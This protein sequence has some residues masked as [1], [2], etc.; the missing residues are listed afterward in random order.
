MRAG[1]EEAEDG[2]NVVLFAFYCTFTKCL[3]FLHVVMR[4]LLWSIINCFNV[5]LEALRLIRQCVNL[6]NLSESVFNR[7]CVI[8][9]NDP[10][11]THRCRFPIEWFAREEK[12][13]YL[14]I[15]IR[16]LPF[17]YCADVHLATIELLC[18]W[19]ERSRF[20]LECWLLKLLESILSF[21]TDF[22]RWIPSTSHWT[23]TIIREESLPF[24]WP[25]AS[26]FGS[27]VISRVKFCDVKL[28]SADFIRIHVDTLRFPNEIS[29]RIYFAFEEFFLYPHSI[30]I[31]TQVDRSFKGTNE[32][33]KS[34]H[35]Q[36]NK[37]IKKSPTIYHL[38]FRMQRA[39]GEKCVI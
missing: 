2:I 6:H 37:Q 25:F 24:T 31:L 36:A 15:N 12:I 30:R 20:K 19:S 26:A 9:H 5:T 23:T 35:K 28:L 27:P 3:Y 34:P 29:P 13:I 4:F 8:T 7:A 18:C 39:T 38:L 10:L 21:V 1:E 14:F 22:S 32:S 33:L 16:R 11:Y 17:T